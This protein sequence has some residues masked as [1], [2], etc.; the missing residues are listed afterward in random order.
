MFNVI[1]SLV[2]LRAYLNEIQRIEFYRK[3]AFLT[4][5]PKTKVVVEDEK[6]RILYHGNI[7][8]LKQLESVKTQLQ[9]L[10]GEPKIIG[11][12]NLGNGLQQGYQYNNKKQIIPILN[13]DG[14]SIDIPY[15]FNIG[16]YK[17]YLQQSDELSEDEAR[18]IHINKF[19]GMPQR[20]LQAYEK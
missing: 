17:K 1:F 15:P 6:E 3:F 8:D 13:E 5:I 9:Q 20:N 7:Q 2:D 12:W 16:E 18:H 11:V 14:L 19:Y 4:A 10:N